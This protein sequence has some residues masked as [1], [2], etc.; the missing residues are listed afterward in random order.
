MRPRLENPGKSLTEKDLE[1]VE[2][3]LDVK[4]PA[5][6]RGFLLE[7]NGGRPEPHTSGTPIH[8]FY[9]VGGKNDGYSLLPETKR[10]WKR[11]DIPREMIEIACGVFG[12]GICL[13]VAGPKTGQVWFWDHEV[14]GPGDEE[15]RDHD[16]EFDPAKM[17]PELFADLPPEPEKPAKPRW[18]DYPALSFLAAAFEEFIN[19]FDEPP[20]PRRR[21]GK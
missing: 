12:D 21:R 9:R 3:K 10:M 20:L 17:F 2:K 1:A 18:P 14:P 19:G 5:S 11:S 6:Y 7:S 16:K 8:T 15:Y 4:L 13:V